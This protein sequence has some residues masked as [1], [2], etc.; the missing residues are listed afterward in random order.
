MA[1]LASGKEA[2]EKYYNVLSSVTLIFK[3][4]EVYLR[5]IKSYF[6]DNYLLSE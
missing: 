5:S 2:E 4:L 6:Q 3:Q 1:V